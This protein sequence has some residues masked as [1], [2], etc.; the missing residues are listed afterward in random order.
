M[1]RVTFP[2]DF[3]WGVATSAQQIEG[4]QFDHGRGESIWDRYAA[5]GKTAGG[6]D[7]SVACDHYHRWRQDFELL[8][9][10]GV[11]AYR[12]SIAWPRILPT[13]QGTANQSGVDFYDKLVD[14]LLDLGIAPF[15]TLN[16]WDMPQAL[17][18]TGGW[19]ARETCLRFAEYV[20]IVTHTLGDRVKLWATHNEP[21]CV[22]V[23]GYETGKH[24]PG[25]QDPKKAL[26]ASHHLLLSHGLA[27]QQIRA[28]S[29]GS[30]AGMVL[31]LLPVSAGSSSFRDAEAARKLD[32]TFNRWYMDPLYFGKYPADVIEDRVAKGHLESSELPF[33]QAGDMDT[34][35]LPT[36][37]LGVNYYSRSVVR[38]DAE[39]E[40]VGVAMA[41]ESELTDMGWEVY[42]QGLTDLLIR[43][44]SD[45]KPG[46]ILITENGAAYD[47][48]PDSSGRV[49][50]SLRAEYL[51]SHLIALLDAMKQ[52][53]PVGGYFAWTLMDNFEWADGYGRRFGLYY[54][55]FETQERIPKDSSYLYRSIISSNSLDLDAD[56]VQSRRL[57]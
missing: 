45:Y 29:P 11:N 43:M 30:Q 13:G 33:V 38:A 53:V 56:T 23:L 5:E 28:N 7:S 10:L 51:R 46:K 55:D 25:L 50:D 32:G 35:S 22:S 31:N 36:D 3:L 16:H 4:A 21:W 47:T 2:D 1:S 20:S 14:E 24:A 6:D 18:E 57:L 26:L 41:P 15:I 42:P 34:I 44:N 49:A 27:L 39:G 37:Y 8:K 40:P 9:D 52:G 17:Q 48:A 12:F 54:V 19:T